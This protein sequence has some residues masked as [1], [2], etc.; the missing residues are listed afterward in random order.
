MYKP[1][2]SVG[3]SI[4][5]RSTCGTSKPVVSRLTLVSAV[6][7]PRRKAAMMRS[8]SASGVVPAIISTLTPRSRQRIAHV[9]GVA[10]TTAKDQPR[11]P[12]AA[13]LDY[14]VSCAGNDG[15]IVGSLLKLRS[16]EF[17]ATATDPA[18]VDRSLRGLRGKRRQIAI[19]NASSDVVFK[20]D[21]VENLTLTRI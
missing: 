19:A 21:I 10:N 18:H 7:S 2:L 14:F 8:R 1:V 20:D 4:A 17:A 11:A 9:A 6:M 3:R 15:A 12:V 5:S 13:A 16:N